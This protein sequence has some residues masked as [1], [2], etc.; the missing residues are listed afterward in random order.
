MII[1]L[2]KEAIGW[3]LSLT[4][5]GVAIAVILAIAVV[6]GMTGFWILS[7][8]MRKLAGPPAELDPDEDQ[9]DEIAS[10]PSSK[11]HA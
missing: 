6:V 10:A 1:G 7:R 11:P 3:L 9:P 5:A 2:F 8:F 4:E